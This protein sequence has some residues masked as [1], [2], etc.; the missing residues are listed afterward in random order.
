MR[1]HIW[2]GIGCLGILLAA[3]LWISVSMSRMHQ[4]AAEL[5][6]AAAEDAI[7]G[8]QDTAWE[9][10]QLAKQYW[11]EAKTLTAAVSDHTFIEE[12]D[13]LFCQLEIYAGTERSWEF[14]GCCAKL[15]SLIRAM[16]ESHEVSWANVL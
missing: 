3:G 9:Q 12:I 8:Q 11:A 1:K 13:S 2:M 5:L 16:A 4:P 10:A 7:T 14:A 15:S 6:Q